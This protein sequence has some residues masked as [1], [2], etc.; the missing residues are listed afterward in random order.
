M[1]ALSKDTF[2]AAPREWAALITSDDVPT[3][4][5][6]AREA[7]SAGRA[8]ERGLIVAW[9]RAE[10]E[11]DEDGDLLLD[12]ADMVASGDHYGEDDA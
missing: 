5:R 2:W 9:L 11:D 6:A 8:V 4:L 7:E 10:A 12:V 3:I 1:K